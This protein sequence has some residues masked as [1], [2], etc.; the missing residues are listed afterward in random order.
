MTIPETIDIKSD[1]NQLKFVTTLKGK[2]TLYVYE[3]IVSENKLGFKLSLTERELE[4]LI[5]TNQ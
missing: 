2:E 5:S 3:Y 4:K 1:G